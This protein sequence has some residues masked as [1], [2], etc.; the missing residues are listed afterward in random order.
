MSTSAYEMAMTVATAAVV[1]ASLVSSR[2]LNIQPSF[3]ITSN[4]D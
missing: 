2:D 4:S 1:V 3:Q